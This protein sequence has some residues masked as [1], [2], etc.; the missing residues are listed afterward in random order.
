MTLTEDLPPTP[1]SVSTTELTIEGI[2]YPVVLRYFETLN[3]GDFQATSALFADT[4]A[5]RPPFEEPVVGQDAIAAYLQAEAQGMTLSP[6]QGIAETLEDGQTQVQVTG[7][8]QT[9][10]FGVNVSWLFVLSQEQEILLTTIKLLAS[11][12]ELLNIRR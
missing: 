1:E 5:M 7:K 11:P 2:A 4:G 3:A 8:V 12:Q 10:W 9:R 6:H